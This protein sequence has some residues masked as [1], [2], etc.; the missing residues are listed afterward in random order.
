LT[1]CL[2]CGTEEEGEKGEGGEKGGGEKEKEEEEEREE[3]KKKNNNT[4][5]WM[6]SKHMG[7]QINDEY[8]EH[9]PERS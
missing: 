7:L 1:N 2:S 8:Y 4:I 3:E 6:I 9:I 5:H